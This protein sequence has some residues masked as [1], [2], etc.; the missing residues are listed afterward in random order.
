MGFGP[1]VR[2]FGTDE[3][4]FT[5]A[6]RALWICVGLAALLLGG[7]LVHSGSG[8]AAQDADRVLRTA[9]GGAVT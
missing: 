8:R 1:A 7:A 2:A 4:A 9:G 5:G 6:E 3:S